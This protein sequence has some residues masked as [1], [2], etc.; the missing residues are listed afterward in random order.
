MRH[1]AAT[2]YAQLPEFITRLYA[3]DDIELV[4]LA[5]VVRFILR[6]EKAKAIHSRYMRLFDQSSA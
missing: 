5:L 3:S 6:H 1:H 2:P 4:R